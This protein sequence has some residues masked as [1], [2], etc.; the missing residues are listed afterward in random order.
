VVTNVVV[1]AA[2]GMGV[3]VARELAPRG[4][5]LLADRDVDG[6]TRVA[7]EIGG[8]VEAVAFDMTDDAQRGELV[9]RIGDE[10]GAFVVTAA[11]SGSM[12]PGRT[13]FEVN[14]IGM[15]RL[16][17]AVLPLA[18]PG[19]VAVCFSS[20]S[21]HRV[22]H[23]P[24]IAAALDE[25]LA[26]DF[27]DRLIAA[28]VDPDARL[29]YPLSKL[30]VHQLVRRKAPAWGARG[31]RILSLSPGTTDTPMARLEMEAQPIMHELI[32][33]RPLA[34]IGRPEE[35]ASVVGFLTSEGASYMTGSDV[36]VDGGMVAV[37]PDTTGGRLTGPQRATS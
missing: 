20:V 36:L 5:M 8:D 34:R 25:P 27:F 11:V 9:A 3:A 10:L 1:G 4:R 29:A 37:T 16:L 31:A 2:S 23:V 22:P 30:G 6:V 35:I 18:G 7:A 12:A 33:N 24:A 15:E 26:P 13:I 19:S 17:D 28:G 21:G 32:K 14:L